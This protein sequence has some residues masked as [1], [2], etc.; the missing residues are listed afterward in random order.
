[1]EQPSKW[2]V[3]LFTAA[4]LESLRRMARAAGDGSPRMFVE[5][6]VREVIADEEQDRRGE[7]A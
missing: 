2:L 3:C 6:L 4:E 5:A 1:M 7:A